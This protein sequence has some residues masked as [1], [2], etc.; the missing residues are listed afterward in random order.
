MNKILSYK[1]MLNKIFNYFALILLLSTV[2]ASI[3]VCPEG[4]DSYYYFSLPQ[5]KISIQENSI[6][7][8][9]ENKIKINHCY[10]SLEILSKEVFYIS[11][12]LSK[13]IYKSNI[14]KN[15]L[16]LDFIYEDESKGILLE[17]KKCLNDAC[18]GNK[19]EIIT[20]DPTIQKSQ[21]GPNANKETN[22]KVSNIMKFDI[23]LEKTEIKIMLFEKVVYSK[24]FDIENLLGDSINVYL[25]SSKGKKENAIHNFSVC[26]L[27][28]EP[29][30]PRSLEENEE[31]ALDHFEV[32]NYSIKTFPNILRD[33]NIETIPLLILH[34]KS[35]N[36]NFPS[37]IL[38][39][40]RKK[41]K[42]L[43][44]I[45]HNKNESLYY[46]VKIFDKEILVIKIECE[47]PGEIYISSDYFKNIDKYIINI[48]YIGNQILEISK[49]Y[50]YLNETVF[51]NGRNS[52]VKIIP[53]DTYDN[54]MS[55]LN[56]SDIEKFKL[57][58]ILTN[59]TVV[60]FGEARFDPEEK[61]II[62]DIILNYLG[63][64]YIEVKYEDTIITCN[65]CNISLD[66][67]G[68]WEQVTNIN[69][70]E[71]IKLGEFS[72]LTISP[73]EESK[74]ISA[75]LIYNII[76]IKCFLDDKPIEVISTL[77]KEKNIIENFSLI[78]KN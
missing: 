39:Y 23:Y 35:K 56:K 43:F 16:S 40:P 49:T 46:Q 61:V 3:N 30:P 15:A 54:Q 27:K 53:K 64:A 52:T 58:A 32:D 63:K 77:N 62:F 75:E 8:K 7:Y 36:G 14:K 19:D 38:N 17:I 78:K 34:P 20:I 9:L 74:E 41:L 73:K 76:E 37:E 45:I 50:V 65:K 48:G 31:T 47:F 25:E 26:Y 71:S 44:N 59:S 51:I 68:D 10:M 67:D 66:I 2:S 21:K 4:L 55:S 18:S 1:K 6:F 13:H 70:P 57:A 24:K 22:K 28:G 42:H 5:F 60:N 33:G 11:L 29:N 12:I 72:N 69:Y